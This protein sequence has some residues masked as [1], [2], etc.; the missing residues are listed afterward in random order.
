[1][2]FR[3]QPSWL[4]NFYTTCQAHLIAPIVHQVL[5]D[6]KM[7]TPKKHASDLYGPCWRMSINIGTSGARRPFCALVHSFF[8]LFP[9]TRYERCGLWT[10]LKVDA[11][12]QVW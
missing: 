7:E 11:K 2:S 12:V 5:L 4:P 6:N 8:K 10:S 9:V 1:M 3:Q